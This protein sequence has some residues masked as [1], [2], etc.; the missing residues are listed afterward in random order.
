MRSRVRWLAVTC[1]V[2]STTA[3]GAMIARSA[4]QAPIIRP[5]DERT[6]REYAGPY[7]WEQ[8]G[9]VY[10]EM[11]GEFTGTPQLG[12]FDESGDVRALYPTDR[13]RFFAGPGMAVSTA[14]ESR[15]EFQRDNAGKL[16]SLRWL[17]DG[18]AARVA[19]RTDT[20]RREEVSFSNGGVQLSGTLIAPTVGERHPAIVLVHASGPAD[21]EQVLPFARFLVGHGMAILGFDKRGVG[22]ST[23]DWNTASFEDLAGDAVAAIDYL[24]TRADIDLGQIGV[25]GWSQAGWIMP[26]VA[27]RVSDL[28]FLISISGAGIVPAETTIDQAQNEMKARGMKPQTIAEI[29]DLMKLQYQFAQTGQGWDQYAAAREKIAAWLGR[30]PDTFPAAADHPSWQVMRRLYFHDPAPALR[31]LRTPTLAIFGELDQNIV[32]QRNSAA[33]QAALKEGGHRDYT[34]RT[35]PRAN[36]TQLEAKSG[37]IPETASLRRFVPEYASTIRDWL[38]ARVRGFRR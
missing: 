34:L 31:Q 10:V 15:I 22:R 3:A 36:H 30:P 37:A 23:G 19:R 24:K 32:A 12:A 27:G 18:G 4:F 35:L 38:A 28:A 33:W 9:F 17:Q 13:D 21:R 25:V 26:L 8:G 5:V 14:V 11:W 1:A 20:E 6:L 29:V 7:Q 16:I 2:A